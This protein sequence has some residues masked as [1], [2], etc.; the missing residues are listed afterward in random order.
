VTRPCL[1]NTSVPWLAILLAVTGCAKTVPPGPPVLLGVEIGPPR[2]PEPD[3]EPLQ[4]FPFA[5]VWSSKP[6]LGL[7][8]EFGSV[9]SIPRLF[10]RFETLGRD[11]R[12]VL[13]RCDVC[14]Q[15]LSGYIDEDLL[16]FVHLAPEVSAW[17]SL[18]EF[19]LS[20]RDAA[21]KRDLA[22][23]RPVMA[24]DFSYS[25]VGEQIPEMALEVWRSEE[26]AMLDL[27]PRLLDRGL[28]TRD[29][30][31]WSAPPEFVHQLG[32]QGPRLG[33]RQRA[34]GRW[35]WLYLI[36]GISWQ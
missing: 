18:A 14:L 26:F 12:G 33:F 34:E 15:P 7:V 2:E 22:A 28:D 11:S 8:D 23:L 5:Q 19:A 16:T 30:R 25:F 24:P 20:V 27:V 35:E 17:G 6:G 9:Q 21:E 3:P 29:G 1:P 13:V 10:T 36:K 4:P 31:V 32:Y